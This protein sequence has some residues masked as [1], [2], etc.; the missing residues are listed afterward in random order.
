MPSYLRRKQRLLGA[1]HGIA[2]QPTHTVH[3]LA[4]DC[5]STHKQYLPQLTFLFQ[6]APANYCRLQS[7]VRTGTEV[8]I[9]CISAIR[10]W[11][12]GEKGY[13]QIVRI[14]PRNVHRGRL[15][16][17]RGKAPSGSLE[18]LPHLQ[19]DK[20]VLKTLNQTLGKQPHI[21]RMQRKWVLR[22]LVLTILLGVVILVASALLQSG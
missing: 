11:L 5:G 19:H 2:W 13:L 20:A 21:C 7:H 16:W 3:C 17:H 12:S 22:T 6:Y 10:S 1:C 9:A 14:C 8:Q 4:A 15:R 18:P